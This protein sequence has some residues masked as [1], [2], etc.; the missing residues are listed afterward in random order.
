MA[1]PAALDRYGRRRPYV[2]DLRPFHASDAWYS[3]NQ[4]CG[5]RSF[6]LTR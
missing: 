6:P 4:R 3:I 1:N 5:Y 2:I